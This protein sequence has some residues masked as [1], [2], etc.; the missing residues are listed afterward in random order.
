MGII[1]K[2]ND[3]CDDFFKLIRN[4]IVIYDEIEMQN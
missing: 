2:I 3:G 1:D 4:N